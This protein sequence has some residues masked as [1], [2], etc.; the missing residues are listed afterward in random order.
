[1]AFAKWMSGPAGRLL[2]FAAGLVL[3]LVG[4]LTVGGAVGAG[5]SLFGVVAMAAGAFNFCLL[6]PLFGAPFSGAKRT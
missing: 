2:R 5:L 3:L 4:W 1:M 6:A